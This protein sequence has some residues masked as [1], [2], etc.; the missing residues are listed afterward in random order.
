MLKREETDSAVI[1][2]EIGFHRPL[3]GMLYNFGL[4]IGGGLLGLVFS[5][6]LIPNVIYPFPEAMGFESLTKNMFAFYF[7]LADVGVGLALQR[8]IGEMR[9]RQPKKTIQYLQ[10][11]VVF[12]MLTGLLQ[13]TVISIWVFITIQADGTLSYG[14][15]FFLFYSLIQYPGMLG[16]FQG[17]LKAYQR[18]DKANL[19]GFVQGVVFENS[20]RVFCI[21]IGRILGRANPEVGELMGATIGSIVGLYLDDFIAAI[22]A[23]RMLEPIVQEFSPDFRAI[24]VFRPKF[25]HDLVKECIWFGVKVMVPNIIFPLA[26]LITIN[27]YVAYLPNY[28]TLIGISKFADDIASL[29][30]LLQFNI[31]S[32]IS[33]AYNNEKYA[34]TQDY[35]GR[36]YRWVGISCSFLYAFMLGTSNYLAVIVGESYAPAIALLP[37]L[38]FF[39]IFSAFG[40]THDTI[41]FGTGRPEYKIIV[42]LVEQTSR[43]I[44]LYFFLTG[45]DLGVYCIVF[46]IG[47]GWII[48]WIVSYVITNSKVIEIKINVWQSFISAALAGAVEFVYIAGVMYL[49]TA[50]LAGVLGI[51]I[52][53]IVG[54]LFSLLT[55]PFIIFFIFHGLFGGWDQSALEI[56]HKA[57]L[58]SGPSKPLIRWIYKISSKFADKSRLSK[59]FATDNGKAVEEISELMEMK[60]ASEIES[61]A[62]NGSASET[63]VN[64]LN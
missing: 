46:S 37:I 7:T 14:A 24:D 53:S 29:L 20:T 45:T 4:V 50:I 11:F 27:L 59:K 15:Y 62:E 55:G 43:V 9:V 63:A 22:V 35:I 1:W 10:F 56:L 17:A 48:K 28:S 33:E 30:I 36:M 8:Y 12:Q 41:F 2:D 26:N 42:L 13:I 38:G 18:F 16:V 51:L 60:K 47:F 44:L 5:L 57:M 61:E 6:W 34:L 23:A 54:V 3:G 25:D 52:A 21:I 31:P 19:I 32:T 40:E 39:R 49:F 58:I 64:S